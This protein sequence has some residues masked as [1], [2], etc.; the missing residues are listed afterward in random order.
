MLIV[1]IVNDK[2]VDIQIKQ[3]NPSGDKKRLFN[4]VQRIRKR[5][6]KQK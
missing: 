4:F 6:K 1:L 5:K 2:T 3:F